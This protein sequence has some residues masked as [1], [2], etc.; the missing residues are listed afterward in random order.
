MCWTSPVELGKVQ[1]SMHIKKI[2]LTTKHDA[3]GYDMFHEAGFIVS[4]NV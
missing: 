1:F 4:S 3:M 2:T